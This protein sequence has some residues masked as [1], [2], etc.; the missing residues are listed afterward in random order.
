MKSGSILGYDL[1]E[2]NCQISFY[3]DTKEEPETL[4]ASSKNYQI[5]LI[6]GYHR[7][8]WVY[9][10]EAEQ[11]AAVQEGIVVTDLFEK[12]LRR[13]KVKVGDRRRD[14]VWLLAKFIRMS[15]AGFEDIEFITFSV[16]FTNIDM[17]KMLK[18]IGRHLGISKECV[19]VQ[20]YKESFCQYMFYQPKELW[21][22]ESAM[23]YC[24]AKEIRAY[25]L[26]R[27][28]AVGVKER[29]M[30]V[31]VEEVAHAQMKELAAI[32]P[33]L[34]KDK[35]KDA[36]DRFKTF[37]QS[38]FEK[39]V[40][41]SVY[42]TGEAFENNW[43]P[44]SLK[45]LCNGRRAFVG[46]NLYSRGACYTSLRKCRGYNDTP[47][48]LDDTKMMEQICLRM[49]VNGQEG[50][51]PIVSWGTHWYEADGQW[52]VILEDTSDI[53][54]HVETLAG[55]E[56][57]VETVSLEGLPDRRDYSLRIQIEVLF[58]DERTCRL[59]F[60][61]VG[62]GE[63]FPASGFHVEKTIHLGGINGQFNSMS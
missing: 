52:E 43:Y 5:P 57:Q 3:D 28:N 13:E 11:L 45:V 53:E 26:R 6:L 31:T 9:G 25:M 32:Y 54:I 36:D 21:Q 12:A 63:F 27:L 34:N 62:F 20:D 41:S 49:R 14:A 42:L 55:E 47:T 33:I 58:L 39:K 16:P 61:D 44:N 2:K 10:I 48:Y 7:E 17:S 37:I 8:R 24:D 22:Y 60:K 4:E 38:V 15:L 51:Y 30:F 23:F 29:E 50:W 59:S 40:V 35:A 56:L 19:C 46:N 18:G 1:N